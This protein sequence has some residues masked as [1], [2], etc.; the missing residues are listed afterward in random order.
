[1]NLMKSVNLQ[2]PSGVGPGPPPVPSV[3]VRAPRP[4]SKASDKIQPEDARDI[5]SVTIL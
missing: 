1:M 3:Q 2:I 4:P 5:K